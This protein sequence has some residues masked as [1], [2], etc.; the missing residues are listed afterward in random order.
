MR[1]GRVLRLVMVGWCVLAVTG[2][3][4]VRTLVDYRPGDPVFMSGSRFDLAL[5]NEDPVAL[6]KFHSHP[7]DWPWLDLPFSFMADLFFW[8]LPRSLDFLPSLPGGGKSS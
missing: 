1:S 8:L 4:S 2:C 3:A 6:K 5:I 7:P